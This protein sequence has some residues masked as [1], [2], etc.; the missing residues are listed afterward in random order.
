MLR[1]VVT[2][3]N[4]LPILHA[5]LLYLLGTLVCH[6]MDIT[7][8]LLSRTCEANAVVSAEAV[9][10]LGDRVSS[11]TLLA[12]L[13][14]LYHD[15]NSNMLDSLNDGFAVF[16]LALAV[17]E[18][19]S[20]WLQAGY[21]RL[22]LPHTPALDSLYEV[23]SGWF[24]APITTFIGVGNEAFLVMLYL[25]HPQ[26]APML[27]GAMSGPSDPT[28]LPLGLYYVFLLC[29]VTKQV[30]VFVQLTFALTS[31]ATLD[32]TLVLSQHGVPD[33]HHKHHHHPPTDR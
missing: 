3:L 9:L 28:T 20:Y 21:A 22:A 13:A 8:R 16:F 30:L 2:W 31:A 19:S 5:P 25:Y 1:L 10:T 18:F 7:A 23:W 12:S 29:L 26:V 6:G 11:F 32:Q 33:D 17:L 14:I 4:I 27:F 24:P 15:T